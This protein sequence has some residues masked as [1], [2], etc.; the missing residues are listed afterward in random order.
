MKIRFVNFL[1]YNI[2]D[3]LIKGGEKNQVNPVINQVKKDLFKVRFYKFFGCQIAWVGDSQTEN[4]DRQDIMNRF[5]VLAVN[6]GHGGSYAHHYL[7]AFKTELGEQLLEELQGMLV[8]FNIG[9][10]YILKGQMDIA[11]EGMK[12][13][14]KLFPASFCVNVPPIH[15]NFIAEL[16]KDIPGFY[17]TAAEVNAA[18]ADIN[19]IISDQWGLQTINIHDILDN[20][21]DI[22]IWWFALVDIV[23]FNDVAYKKIYV[24]YVNAVITIL[25]KLKVI[26]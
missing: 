18:V 19:Q 13:L 12:E 26:K 7:E 22:K 8:I 4:G 17:K 5:S 11:L 2:F 23:H 1:W 21:D 16:G 6:I 3:K 14:L 24:C 20:E 25:Q 10:N 15:S 9:G